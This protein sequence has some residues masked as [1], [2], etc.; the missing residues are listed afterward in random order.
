M[1]TSVVRVATTNNFNCTTREWAQLDTFTKNNPDKAFFVNSNINTPKLSTVANHNYKVVVT[2]NPDLVIDQ[3]EIILSRLETIRS[4]VAFVRVKYI[5][6]YEPVTK[7]LGH[8][9]NAG[10]K[11]VLTLQRFNSKAKLLQYTSLDYYKFSCSRFRLNGPELE[12][13]LNKISTL[14]NQGYPVWICDQAGTGCQGCGLCSRLT[15]NLDL[16]I[17]SLNLSTSGICPY[18]CPD[19][20]AKTMQAFSKKMGHALITYDIIRQNDKQAGRT[21]HIKENLNHDTR[22]RR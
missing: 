6:N 16:T 13:V 20:Y 7:L 10:F 1:P 19:C 11:V 3:S 18:D 4:N 17:T 22:C 12:K 21:T 8:L 15:T 9:L 2:A 14:Q 5:P